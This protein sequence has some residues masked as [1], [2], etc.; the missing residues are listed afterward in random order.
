MIPTLKSL[1][2]CATAVAP[3]AAFA[4]WTGGYAGLSLG[5]LTNGESVNGDFVATI[6]SDA[7]FE[8][9]AGYQIQQGDFV[10]GGEVA[11][12]PAA[13]LESQAGSETQTADATFSDIKA[14]AGY[15]LGPALVY[16]TAGLSQVELRPDGTDL[17]LTTDGFS[18]GFGAD[19]LINDQFSVGAEYLARRLEIEQDGETAEVTLDTIAVRASFRF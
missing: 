5:T 7:I 4:D 11:F 16:G 6:E 3:G 19:Y 9:L 10:F 13:Q 15:N 2:I 8:G 12:S 18:L 14:R 17:T 1:L